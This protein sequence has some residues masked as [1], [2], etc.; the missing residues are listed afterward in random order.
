MHSY[1]NSLN[2]QQNPGQPRDVL[3]AQQIAGNQNPGE[4]PQLL[5][6]VVDPNKN[7]SDG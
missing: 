1:P 3:Q 2:D 5:D 4:E 6:Q 7:Q